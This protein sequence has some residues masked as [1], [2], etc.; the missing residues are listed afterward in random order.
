M[1][2]EET[3]LINEMIENCKRNSAYYKDPKAEEKAKTLES[4]L[5]L[6]YRVNK[7]LDL[8]RVFGGRKIIIYDVIEILKGE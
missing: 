5:D 1:S 4:V 8:L 7:A 6:Q 2:E 3:L